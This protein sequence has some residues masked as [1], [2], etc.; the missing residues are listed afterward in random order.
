M[1]DF[2]GIR[3][4]DSFVP[5]LVSPSEQRLRR[6]DSKE[7]EKDNPQAFLRVILLSGLMKSKLLG[8]F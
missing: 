3:L 4:Q 5:M 7:T 2:A 6:E 8:N 1:I